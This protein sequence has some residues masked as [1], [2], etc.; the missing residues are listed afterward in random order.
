MM[1]DPQ[2]GGEQRDGDGERPA[3]PRRL[4][5]PDQPPLAQDR[6][7]QPDGRG[8]ER[9]RQ[10][11]ERLERL[12]LLRRRQ[13]QRNDRGQ[14]DRRQP[15]LEHIERAPMRHGEQFGR[16]QPGQRCGALRHADAQHDRLQPPARGQCLHH[17]IETQRRQSGGRH[18]AGG[19]HRDRGGE[20][21]HEQMG[22]GEDRI[23]AGEEQCEGPQTELLAELDQQQVDRRIGHH[24]GDGQ[25]GDLGRVQPQRAL[26][27]HRI[28][29]DQRIA[30]ATGQPD[31]HGDNAISQPS[32]IGMI[33]I[34]RRSGNGRP[35]MGSEGPFLLAPE[36][37]KPRCHPRP[38]MPQRPTHNPPTRMRRAKG[39]PRNW[40]GRVFILS[41]R[42]ATGLMG[43]IEGYGRTP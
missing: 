21:A 11:I 9:E 16:E 35:F 29:L 28:D 31:Q 17:V 1:L 41:H 43:P 42:C 12:D 10:E 24:I 20:V 36:L 13:A 15:E 40:T 2:R 39:W 38:F 5:P 25:P 7:E 32:P 18:A 33:E 26:Q 6:A 19:A 37:P 14:A 23:E 30:E 8:I 34:A 3:D 4:C 22:E 27:L